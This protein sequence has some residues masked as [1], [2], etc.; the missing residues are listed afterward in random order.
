MTQ[1]RSDLTAREQAVLAYLFNCYQLAG[2]SISESILVTAAINFSKSLKCSDS[3]LPRVFEKAQEMA[4]IPTLRVVLEAEK[5]V[6]QNLPKRPALEF[7]QDPPSS[8]DRRKNYE[9]ALEYLGIGTNLRKTPRDLKEMLDECYDTEECLDLLY[10]T[11]AY[12]R[13]LT[14]CRNFCA[15]HSKEK[16]RNNGVTT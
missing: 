10:D 1:C 16:Y 2:R 12:K 14:Y 5:I 11:E 6:M 7:K 15:M 3:L 8:H 13:M 4:D 9:R